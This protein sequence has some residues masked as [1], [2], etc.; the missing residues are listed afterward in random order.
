MWQEAVGAN[1]NYV[2]GVSEEKQ[3]GCQGSGLKFEPWI[4]PPRR[5]SR[6]ATQRIMTLRQ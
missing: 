1:F 5:K 6:T 4:P 2:K 3:S